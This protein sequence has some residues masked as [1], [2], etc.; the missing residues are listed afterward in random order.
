MSGW[1]RLRRLFAFLSLVFQAL[2]SSPHHLFPGSLT[3]MLTLHIYA[4]M[5]VCIFA[6]DRHLCSVQT[7]KARE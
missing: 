5:Y 7:Q 1:Q 4:Y 6:D 3:P 2:F